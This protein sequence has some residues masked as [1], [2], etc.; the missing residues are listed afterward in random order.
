MTQ[1]EATASSASPV[2]SST[3]VATGISDNVYVK[4]Q[5]AQQGFVVE[6]AWG[7]Y[8]DS[9]PVSVFAGAWASDLGQGIL[10]VVWRF[11]LRGFNQE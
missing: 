3:P 8:V 6:N 9:N 4:A 10:Q 7:G 2:P 1:I 11:P 5:W